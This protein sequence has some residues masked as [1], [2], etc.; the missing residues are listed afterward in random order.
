VTLCPNAVLEIKVL[1]YYE[2]SN[3]KLFYDFIKDEIK[4]DDN[5]IDESGEFENYAGA[6]L[7]R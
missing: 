7:I 1:G 2:D 3:Y 4:L 6:F 5:C